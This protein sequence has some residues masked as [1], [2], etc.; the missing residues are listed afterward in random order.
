MAHPDP[1]NGSSARIVFAT[2]LNISNNISMI[3]FKIYEAI[4]MEEGKL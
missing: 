2:A 3:D 1:M 4:T